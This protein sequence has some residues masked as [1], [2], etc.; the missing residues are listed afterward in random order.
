MLLPERFCKPVAAF[1]V[2]TALPCEGLRWL[3]FFGP[4]KSSLLGLK[5]FAAMAGLRIGCHPDWLPDHKGWGPGYL[6]RQEFDELV[7]NEFH[8]SVLQ[9][10]GPG[11]WDWSRADN[12]VPAARDLGLPLRGHAI[13]W[14]QMIP[15]WFAGLPVKERE[16]ALVAHV[17]ALVGR[18][19][20]RIFSW[21][22]INEPLWLPDKNRAGLR[23]DLLFETFG[24]R[25]FD[26]AFQTAAETAPGAELVLNEALL[27]HRRHAPQRD[28]FH[29]LLEMLLCRGVPVH[30]AGVQ[31]HIA[32]DD[33]LP[34]GDLDPAGTAGLLEAI[35]ELNLSNRITELDVFDAR[36][37]ASVAD[38]D[39]AVASL[40][41]EFLDG[42]LGADSLRGIT[43]WGCSDASSWYN[44]YVR[45]VMPERLPHPEWRSRPLLFDAM[46]QPKAAY[47]AFVQSLRKAG[48]VNGEEQKATGASLLLPV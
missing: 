33:G 43:I 21:D 19:S 14:Y 46:L 39:A 42:V 24:D 5:R 8:W 6:L 1:T 27:V 38:R 44:T 25:N 40:Y 3:I 37:P 2:K 48:L 28:K 12:A 15:E 4:M 17:R 32:W 41:G 11:K 7:S 18:Y 16:K 36:L 29:A 34:M 13:L 35:G 30:T 47:F 22:V 9:P 31:A 10:E 26:I 20:D 23:K 45:R